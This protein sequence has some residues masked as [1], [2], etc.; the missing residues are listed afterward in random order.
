MKKPK[1]KSKPKLQDKE[2]LGRYVIFQSERQDDNNNK[3][4]AIANNYLSQY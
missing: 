2:E 4:E 3:N 1:L